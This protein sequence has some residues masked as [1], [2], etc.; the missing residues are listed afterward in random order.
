MGSSL[1]D[2]CS[3]SWSI[4]RDYDYKIL[5]DLERGYKSWLTLDKCIDSTAWAY[6]K[7][8]NL[9]RG[10]KGGNNS[11]RNSNSN[12]GQKICTTYNSFRKDGCSWEHNN[13]G[14]KCIFLHACSVCRVKGHKAPQCDKNFNKPNSG[15]SAATPAAQTSAASVSV[16]A[17][18][19]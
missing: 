10:Q 7:E 19:G 5:R 3:N 1:S 9:P 6:S 8:M 4:A 18:S 11:N 17:T 16:P 15:T 13:P 12:N 2:F 14:E